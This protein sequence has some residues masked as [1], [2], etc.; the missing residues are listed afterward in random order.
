MKV[1]VLLGPLARAPRRPEGAAK[2]GRA[3]VCH[4]DFVVASAL[5]PAMQLRRDTTQ[6]QGEAHC[7]QCWE[8]EA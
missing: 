1:P 2:L 4:P 3:W 6:M 7:R 8:M 5:D